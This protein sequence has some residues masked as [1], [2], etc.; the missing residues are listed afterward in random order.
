MTGLAK[1]V[2]SSRKN[3]KNSTD[4]DEKPSSNIDQDKR[5][6]QHTFQQVYVFLS[7]ISSLVNPDHRP[8]RPVSRIIQANQVFEVITMT[9]WYTDLDP[10][11]R[12]EGHACGGLNIE[13]CDVLLW[14]RFHA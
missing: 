12:L 9:N 4:S 11:V 13:E 5:C 7:C 3:E 6:H 14:V 2:K 8:D 1:E 10:F